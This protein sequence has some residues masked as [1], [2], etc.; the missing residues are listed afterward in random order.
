MRR[1]IVMRRGLLLRK[2]SPKKAILS[3]GKSA[4]RM[5]GR[6]S[7]HIPWRPAEAYR[8]RALQCLATQGPV[9]QSNALAGNDTQ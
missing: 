6:Y 1:L 5:P 4:A 8:P 2:S 3:T 9:R 7:D